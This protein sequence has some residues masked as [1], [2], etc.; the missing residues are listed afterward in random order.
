MVTITAPEWVVYAAAVAV[1]IS[2]GLHAYEIILRVQLA[3][4]KQ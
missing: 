4:L 2:V 3:K 1:W